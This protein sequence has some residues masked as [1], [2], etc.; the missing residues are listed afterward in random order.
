MKA[1]RVLILVAFAAMLSGCVAI[2]GMQYGVQ[3]SFSR[4]FPGIVEVGD[5][6]IN[7]GVEI[8]LIKGAMIS[9]V[10]FNKD[11]TAP[12]ANPRPIDTKMNVVVTEKVRQDLG[13]SSGSSSVI[14][15]VKTFYFDEGRPWGYYYW[16]NKTEKDALS[17]YQKTSVRK[18]MNVH[19]TVEKENDILLEV[20]GLWGGNDQ[21]DEIAGARQLAKEMSDA[22]LKKLNALRSA[23]AETKKE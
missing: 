5:I 12:N 7:G 22:V 4:E 14:I 21:A 16:G 11:M 8:A 15:R 9:S 2:A 23:G 18:A 6:K 17:Y 19:L 10:V 20:H 13:T 1:F 3:E